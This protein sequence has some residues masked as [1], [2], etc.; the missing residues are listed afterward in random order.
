M[1]QCDTW[2][3]RKEKYLWMVKFDPLY[4][5]LIKSSLL[6]QHFHLQLV[7]MFAVVVVI[8]VICWAPYHIYFICSYHYPSITQISYIGHVYLL[9]YWLAMCQTCVNPIIY[10]WMNR[11]V[12][13]M[14]TTISYVVNL[15]MSHWVFLESKLELCF[16]PSLDSKKC[17]SL[18]RSLKTC[19]LKAGFWM[20]VQPHWT[21]EYF[22]ITVIMYNHHFS[23]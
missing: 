15:Q 22:F 23:V 14:F 10:Y 16:Q 1:I 6:F 17:W 20:E 3:E 12:I 7:K 21:L 5:H 2:S 4:K 18:R 9:F 11:L 8:F 19:L 13:L